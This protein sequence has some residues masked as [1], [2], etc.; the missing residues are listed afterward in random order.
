[1][2]LC[3]TE[4]GPFHPDFLKLTHPWWE[5]GHH[6]QVREQLGYTPWRDGDN[7]PAHGAAEGL[8]LLLE[9]TELGE[10]LHTESVGTRQQQ[11]G[12]EDIVIGSKADRALR[13]AV[14]LLHLIAPKCLESSPGID[15]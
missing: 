14:F 4:F 13:D 9:D 6:A 2:R 12:L 15:R 8:Q 3:P 11:W 1:M 10:T 5:L 7:S